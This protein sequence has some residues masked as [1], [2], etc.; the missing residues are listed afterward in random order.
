MKPSSYYAASMCSAFVALGFE[1]GASCQT[2]S[3][4]P[5][6]QHFSSKQGKNDPEGDSEIM[7]TSL[8]SKGEA[9][10]SRFNRPDSLHPVSN[11]F[12][13]TVKPMPNLST[14][15]HVH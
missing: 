2:P 1:L 13:V 10:I 11:F 15:S 6:L 14:C 8:I 5:H 3:P 4:E 7:A 12:H 9:I